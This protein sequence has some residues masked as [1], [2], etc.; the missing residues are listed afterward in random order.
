MDQKH[1]MSSAAP[2]II[3]FKETPSS[4]VSEL[5]STTLMMTY[6]SGNIARFD[7]LELVAAHRHRVPL[8][9]LPCDKVTGNL[10]Q[11]ISV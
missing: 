2:E 9:P 8:F 3:I 7:K 4:V 5:W 11:H 10:L 6:G 1:L